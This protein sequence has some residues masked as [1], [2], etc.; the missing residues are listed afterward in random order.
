MKATEKKYAAS[1]KSI[2]K[3]QEARKAKA[4]L[5]RQEKLRIEQLAAKESKKKLEEVVENAVVRQLEKVDHKLIKHDFYK[6]FELTGGVQSLVS[7]VLAD[8]KHRL[9]YYKMLITLMKA[10]T[11]SK[12][13]IQTGVQ[14]NIFGL[15]NAEGV[16]GEQGPVV[17]IKDFSVVGE[18]RSE[19]EI[20]EEDGDSSEENPD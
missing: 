18:A 11:E 2:K 1:L 9:E 14:V 17:E 10:E 13:S 19:E 16:E 15:G 8:K 3:A 20:G 12:Q 6:A 4:E 5:R 7:W